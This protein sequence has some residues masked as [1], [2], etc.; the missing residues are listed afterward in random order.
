MRPATVAVYRFARHADDVADEGEAPADERLAELSSLSADLQCA[1]AGMEPAH[2]LVA[3]L[4]PHVQRHQLGWDRF[5]ALLSAFRQ[6]VTLHRYFTVAQLEDYCMRSAQPVGHLVLG[7]AGRLDAENRSLS[8]QVC[9]ALQWIN[10]LQDIAIDARRGRFYVP[11]ETLLR[12]GSSHAAIAEATERGCADAALR[13]AVAVE[14]ERARLWIAAGAP[15]ARRVGGR[16]GWELRAVT[17]GGLRILDRL[18]AS[19][20]DA[21][22]KRPRLS[23]SDAL[24]LLGGI[25][26][27]AWMRRPA[28]S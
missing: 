21:F 16:L 6:D 15:L 4:V 5:E 11:E 2:P 23:G 27:L 8:D 9:T 10:F 7:I 18:A 20:Y 17:A 12:C 22:L 19:Q 25:L 24:P 13:T 26:R 14:A 1:R 28:A 3:A